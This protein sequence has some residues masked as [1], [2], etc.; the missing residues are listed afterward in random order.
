MLINGFAVAQRSFQARNLLAGTALVDLDSRDTV[1][2][3]NLEGDAYELLLI[4]VPRGFRKALARNLFG[5]TTVNV[6]L[7]IQGDLAG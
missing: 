7:R 4:S 2:I 1:E 6:D 3:G 5:D